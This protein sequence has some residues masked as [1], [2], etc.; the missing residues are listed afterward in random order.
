VHL[1]HSATR[2]GNKNHGSAVP[3]GMTIPFMNCT[4]VTNP[5]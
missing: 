2:G 1:L 3:Q 4:R 5:E